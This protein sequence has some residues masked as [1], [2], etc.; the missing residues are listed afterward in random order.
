MI[1]RAYEFN[2]LLLSPPRFR[3]TLIVYFQLIMK[4]FTETDTDVSA[5][6]AECGRRLR[7]IVRKCSV[8]G[9]VSTQDRLSLSVQF[10]FFAE[11]ARRSFSRTR[12]RE[13]SNLKSLKEKTSTMT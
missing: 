2:N 9:V 7:K 4:F 13:Y 10:L 12:G 6:P 8:P 1:W 11:I 3:R 5:A